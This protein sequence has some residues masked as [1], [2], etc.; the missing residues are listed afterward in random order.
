MPMTRWAGKSLL[1]TNH[2]VIVRG[3]FH[4]G[5]FSSG[6]YAQ[7]GFQDETISNFRWNKMHS[8]IDEV[9][10]YE[11]NVFIFVEKEKNY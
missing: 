4:V 9:I 3:M 1:A 11:F 10:V 7:L 8:N 5:M 6:F 2:V